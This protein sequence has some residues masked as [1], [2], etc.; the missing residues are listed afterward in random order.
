MSIIR[1]LHISDLHLNTNETE[2]IRM[3]RKLPQYILDNNIE[4]DYVFCTGDIRDSSAEH[5]REPFPSADF[6]KNLCEIRNI[7]LDNLFIVPGNHDVNRTASDRENVV[8]NMLWHDNKSWSR[9]YKTELGNI[10]D[11]TLQALHDGEKEFRSFL[12]KIYDRDKLQLYDDYLKPHFVVETEHF[13]ILHIDSTLAYSEKQNR[14]LIIGSRQLQL[15]LDDLNDSKPT[16]VLSHYAITSLD[17]EERRMVSN[18]LDDY[19]IYLWLAGHE[20]YHDLKPCGY[21]HSIQCGEL[22]IEDRCKST[23]LVGEYDTETGQVDIRAYNWFSPEGWAEYPILWRNSKTYTLRLSTKCNDGRSFECVKAEK[24]NESYKAKMP[25]KIISGLFANIESD[26]EIYSNDNPLVELVNTGKNFVLLGDGGMGKSTMMLDA[27]FRLSKSGK[28]VLFLSLEQLEAFGQSIRACIKDYNLNELILFLDG[29]N[30]VLAEQ[31]FSKEINM[32]AMEK[33]VQI[34][35]SSRGSFLY[36]YGVEGFEDA[37]LLLLRD[38]Q[39]KQV[40]TESQWNE[41]VKNYTLK[42]LLRNPMM[43]SMYQKTYPV[44]EK[45][46]D[47]SFLKWNY[48]V[49]N[50]SDLLENYYTSQIAILL[51]RKDVRGEKIM[52][53]YV[54]IQQILSVIAFSCE[55]VNAFR[56]DTQSFHDLTDSIINVVAFDSV[57]NDIRTKYRLRQKPIIDCFEVEDYLLNESNLLKQSGNYVYFPHQIYRDFLSAKY[58]VKY[59]AADNVDGIWNSRMFPQAIIRHISELDGQMWSNTA[60]LVSDDAKGKANDIK[61]NQIFNLISSYQCEDADYTCLDLTNVRLPKLPNGDISL[62][63]SDISDYSIGCEKD[64]IPYYNILIFSDDNDWLVGFQNSIMTIWNVETGNRVGEWRLSA[65][66]YSVS[67]ENNFL[68]LKIKSRQHD[69]IIAFELNDNVWIVNTENKPDKSSI[70]FNR[71]DKSGKAVSRD[72]ELMAGSAPDGLTRICY[73]GG[74]IKHILSS[75]RTVL[76]SASISSNGSHAVTLDYEIENDQRKI[77]MWDITNKKKKMERFCPGN[78][79]NV[80]MLATGDWILGKTDDRFWCW[81]WYDEDNFYYLEAE[82]LSNSNMKYSSYE[83]KILYYDGNGLVLFDLDSKVKNVLTSNYSYI[84]ENLS[85]AAFL[86]NGKLAMVDEHERKVIFN[87]IRNDRLM[88]VNSEKL[89]KIRGIYAF[90]KEPFIAVATSNGLVSMYHTGTGQR[91]RKLET[92][93]NPRIIAW[94]DQKM[95]VACVSSYSK[96]IV[97]R[98][99]SWDN[100]RKGNWYEAGPRIS[101][102]GEILDVSFNYENEELIIITS[103]GRIYYLSDLFC[104]YHAQTQIINS[105]NVGAYDFSG[106]IC[107]EHIKEELLMNGCKGNLA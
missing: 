40:F 74:Q 55:N 58:I 89:C 75:R 104:D 48:A 29:M 79:Q 36:K 47:I 99:F 66:P 37:V 87:S 69:E 61:Y 60:K 57:M 54:A 8:E 78:T 95:A 50:A 7:S 12:G 38:E 72:K 20:H 5:W 2:S 77:Q 67:F 3:R 39:L 16:I 86:P 22:K 59:T 82:P 9:N 98:Y 103:L 62:R 88:K 4:Y 85:Q 91:T 10:G 25:A 19:H 52:M 53:A 56:M 14:D 84:P 96:V 102:E 28:T 80:Y 45:Y 34:I 1:W 70:R 106:V 68:Y 65:Q 13:N 15:A 100:G 63:N 26:N 21:I 17:P 90:D 83:N 27:C 41:I 71:V 24:N 23:F 92:H 11:S 30:E 31:K 93:S 64:R 6:L 46:R 33:R 18:M 107:D 32:L 105:F 51:N 101:I 76:Q 73:K 49:D 97:F 42:Q 35:V 94:N 44:M 43:A 81:N